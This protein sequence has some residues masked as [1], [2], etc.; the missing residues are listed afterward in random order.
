[1]QTAGYNIKINMEM[2]Y[3]VEIKVIDYLG[4]E[5]IGMWN[6]KTY[7]SK[8]SSDYKRI[9]VDNTEIHITEDEYIKLV[10]GADEY[11]KISNNNHM[12]ELSAQIDK[13]PVYIK[14]EMVMHI[15]Q[16][17]VVE[18]LFKADDD[19]N[20]TLKCEFIYALNKLLTEEKNK[21][22]TG[23]DL[24]KIANKLLVRK[25]LDDE[26]FA[27]INGIELSSKELKTIG[28]AYKKVYG[29]SLKEYKERQENKN[30]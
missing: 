25:D 5:H 12:K 30:D 22:I 23:H 26:Y 4:N 16:D 18:I 1:M 15:L 7:V 6:E 17:D 14:L 2:N 13:M 3:M 19:K 21:K 27:E 8:I 28:G 11:K 29:M 20:I 9:Y 10:G 24:T